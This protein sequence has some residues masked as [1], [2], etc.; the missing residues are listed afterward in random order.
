MKRL[1]AS[2]A[3]AGLVATPAFAATTATKAPAHAAKTMKAKTVKKA[4]A[5]AKK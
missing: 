2:I 5:P 4:A 1:I 3:L